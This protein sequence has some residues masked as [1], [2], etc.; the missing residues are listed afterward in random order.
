VSGET[1]LLA[2]QRSCIM[3]AADNALCRSCIG[4][5]ATPLSGT[6]LRLAAAAAL[7]ASCAAHGATSMQCSFVHQDQLGWCVLTTSCLPDLHGREGCYMAFA[8]STCVTLA[9]SGGEMHHMEGGEGQPT[10]IR[11]VA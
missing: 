6:V 2:G 11:L 7:V 9:V 5:L 4:R 10:L 1:Q 8:V 3:A